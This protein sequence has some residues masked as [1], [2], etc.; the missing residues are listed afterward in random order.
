MP[1]HLSATKLQLYNLCP[2]AFYFRYECNLESAAMF[3]SAALGTALHQ[4]LAH[5]HWQWHY[6]E[7]HPSRAWMRYCWQQHNEGLTPGQMTEGLDILDTYYDRFIATRPSLAKPMAVEGRIQATLLIH[8]IEFVVSG[9]Y[10]RIDFLD[11]GLELIDYKSG[12]EV[13]QPDPTEVDLQL[14]LYCLALE[15]RYQRSLKRL[16]L[17]YLRSGDQVSFEVTPD[18]RQR[19]K[20]VIE[21]LALELRDAGPWKPRSGNQC[22]RCTYLRYCPALQKNPVPLP[23]GSKPERRLQ[24]ALAI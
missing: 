6:Q 9:R 3:G 5:V 8:N 4:A 12:R 7:S 18:H 10:D 13:K 23:K 16:S 2:Q 1:Y 22:D 17:I 14:G 24:L 15:Q 21:T 19:V 11:D 20:D